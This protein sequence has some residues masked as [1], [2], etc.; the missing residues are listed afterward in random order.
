MPPG[1]GTPAVHTH[2]GDQFYF[3][4]KGEMNLQLADQVMKAKAGDLVFIPCAV[5]HRN[6]NDTNE[7]E[8]HFEFIVPGELP[9]LHAIERRIRPDEVAVPPSREALVEVR[10]AETAP[11]GPRREPP[12]E[13]AL[14]RVDPLERIG[15]ARASRNSARTSSSET[16]SSVSPR[17]SSIALNR[18]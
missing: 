6:F 15:H 2:Q 5:P 7:D 14:E 10:G 9:G 12:L 11:L 17:S 13:V 3:I 1:K 4:L 8:I 16:S 18:S